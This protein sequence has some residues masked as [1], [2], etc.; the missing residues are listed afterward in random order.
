[1]ARNG[2]YL[3]QVKNPSWGEIILSANTHKCFGGEIVSSD[4][5]DV[6]MTHSKLCDG[7]IHPNELYLSH[8]DRHSTGIMWKVSM[9]CAAQFYDEQLEGDLSDYLAL[10]DAD[11]QT[12]RDKLVEMLQQLSQ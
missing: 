7:N 5:R 1:M 8:V 6:L 4:G 11:M 2:L 3:I 10:S 12:A 9:F